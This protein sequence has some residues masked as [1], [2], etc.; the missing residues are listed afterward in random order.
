MAGIQK[1]GREAQTLGVPRAPC[2][3]HS[4]TRPGVG[5]Q[6]HTGGSWICWGRARPP[7]PGAACVFV[8]GR[9]SLDASFLGYLST[10]LA[11]TSAGRCQSSNPCSY[12]PFGKN[13]KKQ[14]PRALDT[15]R[16][17]PQ[18]SQEWNGD[19]SLSVAKMEKGCQH[20]WDG[21]DEGC[22]GGWGGV[23]WT[24]VALPGPLFPAEGMLSTGAQRS[25]RAWSL[26]ILLTAPR[27]PWPRSNVT[28]WKRTGLTV[29]TSALLCSLSPALPPQSAPLHLH[30]H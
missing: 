2:W 22:W 16:Y 25:F 9:L 21:L 14:A 28:L 5:V 18:A 12:S 11:P 4:P 23:S 24:V 20:F 29:S 19:C 30:C 8:R 7:K 27:H 10:K 15:E 17:R 6:I 1:R 13:K 3:W 26:R